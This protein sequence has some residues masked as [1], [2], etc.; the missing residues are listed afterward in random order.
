M[1]KNINNND[2]LVVGEVAAFGGKK[3]ADSSHVPI[4]GLNEGISYAISICFISANENG[5]LVLLK[6]LQSTVIIRNAAGIK[7]QQ[8]RNTRNSAKDK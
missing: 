1:I 4:G 2:Y 3:I 8:N 5:R 6:Q 7:T